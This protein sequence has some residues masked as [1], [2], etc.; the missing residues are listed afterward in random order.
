[1]NIGKL[2][3]RKPDDRAPADSS[4]LPKALG[5]V[6]ELLGSVR[7][8]PDRVRGAPGPDPWCRRCSRTHSTL[9]R[10]SCDFVGARCSGIGRE[11]GLVTL[12]DAHPLRELPFGNLPEHSGA[13]GVFW[14][15]TG[16]FWKLLGASR[17]PP[18]RT[19]PKI[20]HTCPTENRAY[21]PDP[22]TLFLCLKAGG[23]HDHKMRIYKPYMWYAAVPTQKQQLPTATGKSTRQAAG[24]T[25]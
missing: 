23:G 3:L 7:E 5:R 15:P 12:P 9:C 19:P 21:M 22:G 4:T 16:W 25:A 17:R 13:L 11:P 1:M 24:E 18:A 8:L 6:R 20:G 10:P 14:K 2:V